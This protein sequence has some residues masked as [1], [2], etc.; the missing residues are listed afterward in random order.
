[1][2]SASH[3]VSRRGDWVADK[4][5]RFS[6]IAHSVTLVSISSDG[7]VTTLYQLPACLHYLSPDRGE[8]EQAHERAEAL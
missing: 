6:G 1:M 7:L 4:G 3:L 8:I 2:R 5:L